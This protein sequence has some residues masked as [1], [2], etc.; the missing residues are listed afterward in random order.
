[1]LPGSSQNTKARMSLEVISEGFAFG[2]KVARTETKKF[3]RKEAQKVFMS[4]KILQAMDCSSTCSLNTTAC[5]TYRKVENLDMRE[6]GMLWSM[7]AIDRD[8]KS[9]ENIGIKVILFEQTKTTCH[10]DKIAF[11]F[12]QLLRVILNC[13][14]LTE[15]GKQSSIEIGATVDAAKFTQRKTHSSAWFKVCDRRSRQSQAKNDCLVVDVQSANNVFLAQI[16]QARESKN[17]LHNEFKAF[18]KFVHDISTTG[19]PYRSTS[20]PEIKPFKVIAC[21]DMSCLWK[22][23]GLGGACKNATYFCSQCLCTKHTLLHYKEGTHQCEFC[24]KH[25][26]ST[27]KCRHHTT[28]DAFVIQSKVDE[29]SRILFKVQNGTQQS[30]QC[31]DNILLTHE[32]MMELISTTKHPWELLIDS[33]LT[34][35]FDSSIANRESNINHIGFQPTSHVTKIAFNNKLIDELVRFKLPMSGNLEQRRQIMLDALV[36]ADHVKMLRIAVERHYNVHIPNHLITI[37]QAMICVLHLENRTTEKVV[38]MLLS[39]GFNTAHTSRERKEYVQGIETI[40]NG[41]IKQVDY[42]WTFPCDSSLHEMTDVKMSNLEGRKF[43]EHLHLL[44]PCALRT[45]P[46]L[47]DKWMSVIN[48]YK[49]LMTCARQR[50]DFSDELINTFQKKAD[51]FGALWISLTGYDGMSNYFHYLFAVSDSDYIFCIQL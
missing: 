27:F 28:N 12:E 14:G 21:H 35:Q 37:K 40:V 18:Y 46:D 22:V 49:D 25:H 9:L 15:Y 48:L 33:T 26:P 38:C 19:L 39:E 20:R 5:G 44:V 16:V 8:R 2:D 32:H 3:V 45:L 23:T 1:M 4:W 30:I 29:L 31:N 7:S 47:Q 43:M 36:H 42:G 13:Y 50:K 34:M 17:L 11:D 24:K 41:S 6:R 51:G 10:S